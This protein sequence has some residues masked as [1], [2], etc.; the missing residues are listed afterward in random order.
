MFWE[1]RSVFKKILVAVDGYGP[2]LGAAKR[3]VEMAVHEGAEVVA[4]QVSEEVPLLQEEKE[5][6]T[7][8]LEGADAHLH[9]AEPLD[10]V[11]TYGRKHGVTV[12]TLKR[13]GLITATILA[14][15][16]EVQADLIVVG[17]A[18]LKGLK[19][20]YFGSVARAVSEHASCPVLIMKKDVAD[21][22]ELLS[23]AGE[24]PVAPEVE[25]PAVKLQPG[26]IRKHLQFSGGLL[27]LF[28]V[29]YF[30]A[31]LLTSAPYKDAAATQVLG[32]PLAI[33][34]GW[35]VLIGGVV[36]TRVF[37]VRSNQVGGE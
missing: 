26:V 29:I 4:L 34:M 33:W 6:E 17:D 36:I 19:K 21:I 11:A 2:S 18:G 14:V 27:A 24:V 5:A 32:L 9:V 20:L 1:V 8:A 13:S 3:A 12:R 37:L 10:L 30:G 7:V 35:A 16:E 25:R 23:I 22:T 15:A 28:V 31:A